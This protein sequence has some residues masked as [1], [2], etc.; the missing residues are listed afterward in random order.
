MILILVIRYVSLAKSEEK[1]MVDKF[2]QVYK[3]YR[4]KTPGFLPSLKLLVN[5]LFHKQSTFKNRKGETYGKTSH[6]VS[7][8]RN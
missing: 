8:S 7:D 3:D 2:G 5:D 1:Q 6:F 4:S